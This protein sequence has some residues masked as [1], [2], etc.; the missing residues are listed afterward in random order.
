MTTKYRDNYKQSYSLA[1]SCKPYPKQD[2]CHCSFAYGEPY[3]LCPDC[4]GTGKIQ[5]ELSLYEKG[6][7]AGNKGFDGYDYSDLLD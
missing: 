4:N 6:I 7:K 5:R 1:S 2:E 3:D